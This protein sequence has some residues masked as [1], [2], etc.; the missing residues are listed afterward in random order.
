[1]ARFRVSTVRSRVVG[2]AVT[3]RA[4]RRGYVQRLAVH[5]DHASRGIGAALVVDG[6]RWLQRHDA[7]QAVVNTQ[8]SNERARRLYERLGF[9]LQ[10]SGLVVLEKPLSS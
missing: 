7:E 3:G 6:L 5:P 2:Y 4:G 1:V 9:R 10:P 8:S